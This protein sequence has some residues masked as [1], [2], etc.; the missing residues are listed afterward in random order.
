M[1]LGT[2]NAVCKSEFVDAMRQ[3]LNDDGL[4]GGNVDDPSVNKNF[5]A[6]AEAVFRIATVHAQTTSSSAADAAF[7]QWVSDVAAWLGAVDA[8]Q[9][10]V[11]A[12][13]TAWTPATAPEIAL[14]TALLAVPAPGPAPVAAPA[15][16]GGRIV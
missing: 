3:R 15:A 2:D 12:A 5:G 4:N 7:W 6:L 10:G 16:L 8:W 1:S 9:N 13:F 14:K 11:T